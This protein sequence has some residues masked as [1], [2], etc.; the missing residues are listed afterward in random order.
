MGARDADYGLANSISMGII[1]LG[2]P[3]LGALT[4]QAPRRMPFLI[5]ATLLCVGFTLALGHDGLSVSLACFV[6]ANIGY[7]AAVL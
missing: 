1:F 7:R 3:L 2:S 5:A 6:I 4:D